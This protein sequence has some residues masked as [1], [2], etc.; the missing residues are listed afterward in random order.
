MVTRTAT[1]QCGQLKAVCEGEPVRISVC[2]CLDCQRRS[3]SAFATQARW[4]DAQ[5]TIIGKANTW[6]RAA[7]SG[8]VLTTRFCPDCGSTLAYSINAQP[9]IIA[10]P[11][12]AFADPHFPAPTR[13]VYE[14]RKHV[15]VEI[16]GDVD[17]ID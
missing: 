11:V 12:G 3:G 7:D 15:W 4:T 13:S 9:G 16:T 10:I 1:C 14:E 17:H 8:N 2:H 5:V 6:A